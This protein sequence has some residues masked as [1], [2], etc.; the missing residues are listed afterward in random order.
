MQWK[1]YLWVLSSW[2]VHLPCL[3]HSKSVLVFNTMWPF[4]ALP[5]LSD[6]DDSFHNVGNGWGRAILE[7]NKWRLRNL[8]SMRAGVLYCHR[9]LI[10]VYHSGNLFRSAI[11]GT[12]SCLPNKWGTNSS[13]P[14]RELIPVYN[15][16]NLFRST[17]S[18]NLFRSTMSGN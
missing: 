15:S 16:G 7:Q 1:C 10:P 4:H 12:H 3:H 14:F 13:L 17:I 5:S 9:E 11:W 2:P 8:A 18:G 6:S